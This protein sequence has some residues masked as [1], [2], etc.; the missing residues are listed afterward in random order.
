[1]VLSEFLAVRK[2]DISSSTMV[3]GFLTKEWSYSNVHA[4]LLNLL[5]SFIPHGL[6]KS[7][8]FS[9]KKGGQALRKRKQESEVEYEKIVWF[10]KRCTETNFAIS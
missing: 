4:L 1:M 3:S 6:S 9:C 8:P 5:F 7:Q 10:E 2:R